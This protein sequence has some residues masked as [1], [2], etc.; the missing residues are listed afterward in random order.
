MVEY[1]GDGY[2]TNDDSKEKRLIGAHWARLTGQCFA[3]VEK[4]LGESDIAAQIRVAA[5]P[6]R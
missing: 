3:M 2:A 5:G 1:K 4:R 6:P